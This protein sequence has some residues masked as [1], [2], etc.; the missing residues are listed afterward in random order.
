MSRS[1][2]NSYQV[3]G[4]SASEMVDSSLILDWVKPDY[5]ID[6]HNFP[7][8]DQHLKGTHDSLL[9]YF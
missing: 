9:L 1:L 6:I 4:E 5:K 2:P 8:N 7:A 3:D